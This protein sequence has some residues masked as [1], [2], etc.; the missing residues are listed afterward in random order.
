MLIDIGP[1]TLVVNGE[2]DGKSYAFDK[3]R[4]VEQVEE[5]LADIRDCLPVLKQKAHK[6][7]RTAY[8][9]VVARRMVDAVK[10]VD[11]TSLTPMAAVAGAV[12]EQLK[13]WL[14]GEG[15]EFLSVN[16]GG[17]I[18]IVNKRSKPVSIG[19]GDV[20]RSR[21]T[22]YILKIGELIDFGVATSGFGGRSFTLGLADIVSVVAS[23][24]PLAD[25]AATYIGNGT[26]F[27]A[28]CVGRRKAVEID[29]STDIPE[30]MVT[31]S[32]GELSPEMVAEA[33]GRGKAV[34]ERLKTEG[35]ISEAV[36]FLKGSM[37]TTI[38]GDN[39]IRLEVA[40]G[41]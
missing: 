35:S 36:I 26:N 33:L 41:N 39:N 1:A 11:E 6:I 40:R 28:A 14:I 12:A 9:P 13:E 38:R 18:A 22:P 21:S 25:A 30:E 32:I 2:K 24:A 7:R 20:Q 23:S 10:A 5:I 34:A 16:N 37:V 27:D 17:D 3:T 8:L 29:P 15:L 31:V 4:L 19:I